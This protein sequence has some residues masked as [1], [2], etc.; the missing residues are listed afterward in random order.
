MPQI[1]LV[2]HKHNDDVGVGVIAQ[3]LQPPR[4]I[5]ICLM[6]ADVVDKQSADC[7]T[8]VCGGD[9]TV[10]LLACSVPNL[11][12]DG[13]GVNLDGASRKFDANRRLG[14]KIEFISRE[15]AQEIGLSNTRISDKDNY[16]SIC[17]YRSMREMS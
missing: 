17:Q 4:H 13:L 12:L 9:S 11:G 2:T 1:A 14:V 5:L 3:L 6:L 7:A 8:V 10:A 16:A 15:A